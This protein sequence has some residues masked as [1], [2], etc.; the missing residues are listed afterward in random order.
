[1]LSEQTVPCIWEHIRR[2]MEEQGPQ[3][4]PGETLA[5]SPAPKNFW[6]SFQGSFGPNY[7]QWWR[8]SPVVM[9]FFHIAFPIFGPMAL[10]WGLGNW[11]S[12]KTSISVKWPEEVMSHVNAPAA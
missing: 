4:L 8:E 2:F 7:F 3:L 12:Y 6:Y 10:F 9:L 1:M 11:F 5:P